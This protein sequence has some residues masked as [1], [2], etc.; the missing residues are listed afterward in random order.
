MVEPPGASQP[1]G[2]P[3]F[4]SRVRPAL[5]SLHYIPSASAFVGLRLC[6]FSGWRAIGMP[7]HVVRDGR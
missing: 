5:S 7:R 2:I 3:L 4:R 1:Q 6:E